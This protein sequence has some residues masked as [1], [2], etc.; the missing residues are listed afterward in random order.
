MD[1]FE[2][3]FAVKFFKYISNYQV[4][5]NSLLERLKGFCQCSVIYLKYS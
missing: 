1:K 2:Q 3:I 4:N 5:E